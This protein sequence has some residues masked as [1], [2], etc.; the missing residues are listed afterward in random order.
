M[1]R[2]KQCQPSRKSSKWSV[3]GNNT[4]LRS[5]QIHK[6]YIKNLK[7][8]PTFF[9]FPSFHNPLTNIESISAIK[10]R[11]SIDVELGIGFEP[12]DTGW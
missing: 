2:L 1:I 7:Y 6:Y 10:K 11:K 8:G 4:C 3:V 9:Y 5:L 12:R